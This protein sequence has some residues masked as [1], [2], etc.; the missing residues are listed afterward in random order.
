MEFELIKKDLQN[1]GS[2]AVR[3]RNSVFIE[4]TAKEDE[5]GYVY[6]PSKKRVYNT[7]ELKKA[8]DVNVFELIPNSP[9]TNLDLVPRPLYN[10]ATRSLELARGT[11]TTQ[12][13]EI[14]ALQS[15]VSELTAISAALD[16]E[17]DGERLLRVTA[18]SSAD[19]LRTQFSLLTDTMQSNTQ[20][21]TLEGIENSSLRARNEGQNAQIES[22][23]KQIDSLTEQLNG[24]NARIAEGAKSGADITARIIEKENVA[25]TDIFY[26]SI[27]SEN[28]GGK[29]VN[30]PTIELFN[31]SVD[32]QNVRVSQQVDDNVNWL[33]FPSTITLQ[34]QEKVTFT[35]GTNRNIINDAG[36]TERFLGIFGGG[37]ARQ[38]KGTLA[39]ASTNGTIS[40][41]TTLDKHRTR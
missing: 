4:A 17:L 41:S 34:P 19:T 13:L 8:I 11:I 5:T 26:D 40:F 29:W 22:F 25:A 33:S 7:D 2:L 21:M 6:A 32:V 31:F 10:E 23:K 28:G 12:S 15:Q 9:E 3:D 18:E 20:R 38:Y 30:G 36:P 1:S 16:I 35:L 14:S 27:V 39:F 37:S 24:K